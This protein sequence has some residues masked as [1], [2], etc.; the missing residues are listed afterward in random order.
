MA[1]A[2]HFLANNIE[3]TRPLALDVGAQKLSLCTWMKG[4]R[5]NSVC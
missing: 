3:N 5:D 4:C 2:K 1:T